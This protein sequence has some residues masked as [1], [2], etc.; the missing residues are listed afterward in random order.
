MAAEQRPDLTTFATGELGQ[1]TRVLAAFL[2]APLVYGSLAERPAAPGQP[3]IAE[4]VSEY[5]LPNVF[6]LERVYGIVGNPVAHSLSPRLH[7]WAYRALGLPALY[8][9]FF[10][11]TFADF[12][13]EVVES[14]VFQRLG[15][16]LAGL[17]VTTPF[18]EPA[19]AVAS[20]SSP[21]A[22][23]IGGANTLFCPRG[24]WEAESTDPEGVVAP[25]RWRGV[26][27][28]R[29]AAVVGCGGAGRAAAL[30]LREAGFEVT[31]VNRGADRGRA[32][33]EA[34]HLE[35]QPLEVFDAARFDVVVQATTL[36]RSA[37]DPLPFDPQALRSD[38]VLV[39]LVYG[40][41]ATPLGE[42]AR[43]RGVVVI[44]G[45][46][47]LLG[48]AI[49]QFRLLTGAEL[50]LAGA[51]EVLGIADRL[52]ATGIVAAEVPR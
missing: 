34:L 47:V 25:L 30:G 14:G 37:G 40:A 23:A 10:A 52:G 11:E 7:N 3:S 15:V 20:V 50:P 6:P 21:R 28:P 26:F 33:A 43:A 41:G 2:G 8:L 44:G 36:G 45:R 17:S 32:A 24:A 9:R 18:K 48:Q 35:W 31:L 46:E 16:E 19:L 4:L 5:D 1:W 42:A 29:A 51:A 22:Q 12:W 27:P 49:D 39:E 13:L 38:A